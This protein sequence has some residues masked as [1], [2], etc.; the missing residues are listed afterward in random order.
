MTGSGTHADHVLVVDDEVQIRRA[1]RTILESRGYEVTCIPAL[2]QVID[3]GNLGNSRM[4]HSLGQSGHPL[5]PTYDHFI[6]DWRNFRYH[7]S[8]WERQQVEGGPHDIL[9]LEPR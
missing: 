1:L 3:L 8:N 5:H 6:D 9:T 7:A 4:I 2:R